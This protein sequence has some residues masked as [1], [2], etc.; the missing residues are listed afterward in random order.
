MAVTVF[1]FPVFHH[2]RLS[3]DGGQSVVFVRP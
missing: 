1:H 2:H 3:E